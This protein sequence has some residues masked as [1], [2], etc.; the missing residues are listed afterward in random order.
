[1]KLRSLDINMQKNESRYT[2]YSYKTQLQ[3]EQNTK[4]QAQSPDAARGD[5]KDHTFIGR[6]RYRFCIRPSQLKK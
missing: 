2:P 6:H 3:M 5:S 1:M 4:C